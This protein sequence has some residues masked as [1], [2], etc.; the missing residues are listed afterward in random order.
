MTTR[1]EDRLRARGRE[2]G[3]V[4]IGFARAGRSPRAEAFR[5]W[6][7]RGFAAEMRWLERNP[8]EREDVTVRSPWVRSI[9]TAALSYATAGARPSPAEPEAG[10]LPYVARYAHGIDYHDVVAERL[11][12]LARFLRDETHGR[13]MTRVLVDTSAILERDQAAS[14]GLGWTAKNAMVIDPDHGSWFFLGEILTDADL[15]PGPAIED[16]CGGCTRCLEAC[17]TGAIVEPRVVDSRKCISYLTIEHR[18]SIDAD[19]RERVGERLF[20]CDVC[21]EV[22]PWND[23]PPPAP[24]VG[25]ARD[26]SLESTSLA[27]AVA[28]DVPAF[29]RRFGRTALARA[30]RAGLVRNAL[31]V[32]ANRRDEEAL[33][34]GRLLLE[35]PD[36][37]LRETAV[38]ALARGEGPERRAAALAAGREPDTA[39]GVR[40]PSDPGPRRG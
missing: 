32:A 3:F 12:M 8:E 26:G 34:A 19:L 5:R 25:L 35:D 29:K 33:R 1:L 14:G 30:K 27:E 9:V 4:R 17:P 18:G 28:L 10:I 38:W 21:Q 39:S 40:A 31:I 20:G 2:I 23:A 7:D 13:A 11:E 22:C 24:G 16:R 37:V 36:P 6:L 15:D